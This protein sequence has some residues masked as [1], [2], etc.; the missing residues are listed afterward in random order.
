[1]YAEDLT[2]A[3]E[4]LGAYKRDSKQISIPHI[5]MWITILAVVV[6]STLLAAAILAY[7]FIVRI[8]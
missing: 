6:P 3:A 5:L 4:R 8:P 2:L 7:S 1:L